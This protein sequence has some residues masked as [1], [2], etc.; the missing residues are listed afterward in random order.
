MLADLVVMF[1]ISRV[2]AAVENIGLDVDRARDMITLIHTIG[3]AVSTVLSFFSGLYAVLVWLL[4]LRY[5]DQ[6]IPSNLFVFAV[7]VMTFLTTIT[8]GIATVEQGGA[9]S[10]AGTSLAANIVTVVAGSISALILALTGLAVLKIIDYN[11]FGFISVLTVAA[12]VGWAISTVLH[13]WLHDGASYQLIS[14]GL[15]FGAA[16]LTVIQASL[17]LPDK[18]RFTI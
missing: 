16:V 8:F 2:D 15:G 4:L 11:K 1:A 12:Y 7:L 9:P 5:P 6:G 18:G 17:H 10:V 13:G 3:F 14:G